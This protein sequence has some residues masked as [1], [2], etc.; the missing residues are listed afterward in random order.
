[1]PRPL[2]VSCA[3]HQIFAV[4]S[5]VEQKFCDEGVFCSCGR[6]GLSVNTPSPKRRRDGDGRKRLATE[7]EGS[8]NQK[9]RRE[10]Y[11]KK[12]ADRTFFV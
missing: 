5:G 4:F 3:N 6:R 8:E 2:W 7:A 1:M 11:A 12:L 10:G 9:A